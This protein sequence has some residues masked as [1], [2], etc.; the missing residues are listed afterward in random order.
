MDYFANTPGQLSKILQAR[1]GSLELTQQDVARLVGL[2]PKTVSAL[3]NRAE[4]SSIET[5]FKCLSAL[6]LEMHLFPKELHEEA[7][8]KT[9]W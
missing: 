4:S 5:L 9:E 8:E 3:E 7:V 1:R 2:L 6:D